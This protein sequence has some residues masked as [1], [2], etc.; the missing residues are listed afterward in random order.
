MTTDSPHHIS[1][2]RQSLC[3]RYALAIAL[4]CAAALVVVVT[5]R[6]GDTRH[7][8]SGDSFPGTFTSLLYVLLRFTVSLAAAITM[9]SL[10]YGIVCTRFCRV[11]RVGPDGYATLL[12]A[13]RSSLRTV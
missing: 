11:G 5:V 6:S 10:V 4:V 9:G 2:T 13:G 12:T 8:A 3:V 1:R 7:A